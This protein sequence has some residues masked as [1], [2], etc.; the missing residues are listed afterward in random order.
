MA[1]YDK[2]KVFVSAALKLHTEG[3]VI[4]VPGN[5]FCARTLRQAANKDTMLVPGGMVSPVFHPA[6]YQRPTLAA[7]K[8]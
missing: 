1:F 5:A 6:Y 3:Q 7:T 4:A 2:D 8:R